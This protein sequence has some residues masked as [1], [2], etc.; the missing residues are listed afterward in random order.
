M[1]IKINVFSAL[2]DGIFLNPKIC[3]LANEITFL[4]LF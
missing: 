3:N 2:G 1:K 4:I